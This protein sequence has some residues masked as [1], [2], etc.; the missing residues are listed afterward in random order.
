ML[1]QMDIDNCNSELRIIPF[2]NRNSSRLHIPVASI[3]FNGM[4]EC[5][6]TNVAGS[7]SSSIF[8]KLQGQLWLCTYGYLHTPAVL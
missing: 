7:D 3:E 2:L 5:F 6:V 8:I 1:N 4:Y